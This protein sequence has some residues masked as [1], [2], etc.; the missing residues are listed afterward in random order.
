MMP[1]HHPLQGKTMATTYRKQ[2]FIQPDPAVAREIAGLDAQRDCQRIAHLLTAYEF[3]WDFQRALELALFYTYGSAS[4]AR[5][6]D[7]TREFSDQ[8]QKRY[9]DTRLLMT[10]I[11][12]SGWDGEVG[13]RAIER[14]NKSH[15]HYRIDR[16]DFLFVLWTFIEFPIR[17]TSRYGKRPM[18]AHEQQA[19]HYFWM[20]LGRRM[21]VTDIP[22]SKAEFDAWV[23]SYKQRTF[24]PNPASARVAAATVRIVEGWLPSRF[25][26]LVTPVVYSFFDDDALFLD[27]VQAPRPPAWLRPLVETA[28]K[29]VGR[30]K[31]HVA[32]GPYPA[33]ADIGANLTYG[34][35][36]YRIEDL[37]PARFDRIEKE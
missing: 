6:L 8:G 29:G 35:R 2:H 11:M 25:R 16:D 12:E 14:V 33:S 22:G 18:T 30:V 1:D 15:G 27:A 7:A 9:D 36:P 37:K 31:R 28:L 4:V 17:W 26:G 3:P 21:N 34:K 13:R 32:F 5:L 24:K 23:E 10:H 19:W 20:E